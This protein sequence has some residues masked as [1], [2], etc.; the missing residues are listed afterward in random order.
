[1]CENYEITIFTLYANGE[2]EKQLNKKVKLES[3]Y[4]ISYSE[5][6]KIKQKIIV[7]LKILLFKKSIYKNKINKNYDVEIAFLEGPITRLFSIKNNKTTKI[8]WIHNDISKVFGKNIKSILKQHIDKSIYSKYK[9]LIFVSKDNLKEFEKEYPNIKC[10]KLVIYNY[11][12]SQRVI[13]KAKEN[14]KIDFSKEVPNFVTVTRLVEQKAID[15]LIN[16]HEKLIKNGMKHKIYVIGD[17]P[18]KENLAKLIKEKNVENTFLLLGKKENPYPYIKNADYFCLM[19]KFEGYGMVIE[20]AKILNKN[21]IIT[22]TAAREAVKNYKKAIIVENNENAIYNGLYNIIKNH[23]K[24]E[25]KEEYNYDN[26][27]R[28]QEIIKIL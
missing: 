22:N 16:V 15:R 18:E 25:E 26:T 12:D 28:I 21:I 6:S 20:E 10:E 4:N 17:G 7:P 23:K 2:L 13:K 14:E 5:L 19:S 27:Q 9:K 24:I 8:A 1:M 11:L 3:M